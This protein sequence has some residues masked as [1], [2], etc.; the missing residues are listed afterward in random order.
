MVQE[1][2]D[3]FATVKTAKN[4]ETDNISR[5]FLKLALPFIGNSLAILFNT[6]IK[7]SQFPD[8]L[9]VARVT[10]I[11]KDGEETNKSNYRPI[12]VLLNVNTMS[13]QGSLK[14]L[15]LTNCIKI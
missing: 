8:S 3:A 9:K 12:L 14:Y 6:S 11:L 5:Y 10:P 13:S 4:F 15:S 2:R 7:T 1:I